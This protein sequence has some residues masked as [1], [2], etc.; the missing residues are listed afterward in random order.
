[1]CVLVCNGVFLGVTFI[2]HSNI[3]WVMLKLSTELNFSYREKKPKKRTSGYQMMG[4]DP[5]VNRRT[6]D[7]TKPFCPV[8]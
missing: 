3:L 1:M 5:K 6:L 7:K 2:F 4:H 8:S